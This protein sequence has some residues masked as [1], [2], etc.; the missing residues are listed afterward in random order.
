MYLETLFDFYTEHK[1]NSSDMQEVNMGTSRNGTQ[2]RFS[3]LNMPETCFITCMHVTTC[4]SYLRFCN[5]LRQCS[6]KENNTHKISSVP[7]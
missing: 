6:F 3:L 5:F 4:I 7:C 2:P 1:Y